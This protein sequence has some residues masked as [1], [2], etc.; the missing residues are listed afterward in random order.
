MSAERIQTT[1]EGVP[2]LNGSLR[3]LE[4]GGW[5]VNCSTSE[6]IIPDNSIQQ[7][8][9]VV[10]RWSTVFPEENTWVRTNLGIPSL[11]VR[12]DSTING[13]GLEIYEIEER[14]AGIGISYVLN[15]EFRMR[16]D[17]IKKTWPPFDV[18]ISKQRKGSDDALWT[19]VTDLETASGLILARAE[20]DETDFHE[21]ESKLVSSLRRKGD[22]SYGLQL[23]M[24]DKVHSQTDL[25]WETPFVLKPLQGS[26]TRDVQIWHPQELRGRSTKSKISRVFDQH[27]EGMYRQPFHPPVEL[28]LNGETYYMIYRVFFGY[29][30]ENHNWEYLSGLWNA[31][32]NLKIH[33]ASDAIFGPIKSQ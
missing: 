22:K 18:V 13:N 32:P 19:N 10:L 26:K 17:S 11:I 20:P 6:A 21:V 14:P 33:G 16:L 31:R 7:A 1:N 8:R 4:L 12:L 24:W 2:S 25:N 28:K 30:L 3:E 23:G 15:E 5:T 29:N 27:S 9:A